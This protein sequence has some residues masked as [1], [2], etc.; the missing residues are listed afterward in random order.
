MIE[1]PQPID[2]WRVIAGAGAKA[3]AVAEARGVRTMIGC[4]DESRISMAAAAHV[5]LALENIAWADLDGHLDLVDDPA[6]GGLEIID[7]RV[8]VGPAAGLGVEVT[9]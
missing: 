3:N 9:I 2:N 5:A 7:G 1:R 4:M 8:G 6:R